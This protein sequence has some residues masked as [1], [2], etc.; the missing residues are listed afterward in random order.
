MSPRYLLPL[1]AAAA[2]IGTPATATA[3]PAKCLEDSACFSW[4][5]MGN[6]KRGVTLKTGRRVT[7]G[8]CRFQ[9][10][11][12]TGK[13]SRNYKRLQGDGYAIRYGCGFDVQ[14]Y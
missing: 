3:A 10:L 6:L 5:T 11:H 8:A 1:A 9:R 12:A 4:S 14:D 13:L 2:F 7:V